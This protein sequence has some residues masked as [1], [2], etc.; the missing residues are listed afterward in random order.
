M[1]LCS[2]RMVAGSIVLQLLNYVE[3]T[4]NSQHSIE[5]TLAAHDVHQVLGHHAL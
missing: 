3:L 4:F 5:I 1:Q 2:R